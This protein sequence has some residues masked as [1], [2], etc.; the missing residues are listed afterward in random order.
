MIIKRFECGLVFYV[1][2]LKTRIKTCVCV[3]ACACVRACVCV[4]ACLPVQPVGL[5]FVES[6]C[7]QLQDLRVVLDAAR[8]SVS[9]QRRAP[10]VGLEAV[11]YHLQQLEQSLLQQGQHWNKGHRKP[12][13]KL[14]TIKTKVK[15]PLKKR[16]FEWRERAT[17][18]VCCEWGGGG[19]TVEE[20]GRH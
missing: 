9:A 10:E 3:C 12:P 1:C 4:C 13:W 5:K 19:V 17:G 14:Q 6:G 18:N 16:S 20:R 7:G 8:Q 15:D 2:L 11:E